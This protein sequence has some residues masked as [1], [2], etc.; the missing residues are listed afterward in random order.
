MLVNT[1]QK[2]DGFH[3]II[4]LFVDLTGNFLHILER[5]TP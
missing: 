4:L 5:K 3:E 1:L 2:A